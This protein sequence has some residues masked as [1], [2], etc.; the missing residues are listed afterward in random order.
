[1]K[2]AL[3]MTAPIKDMEN[4]IESL[5]QENESLKKA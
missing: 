2:L 3:K 1:M 4:Q 5:M